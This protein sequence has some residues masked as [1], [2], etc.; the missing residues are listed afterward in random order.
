[1][2]SSCEHSTA[3]QIVRLDFFL[4]SISQAEKGILAHFPLSLQGAFNFILCC[5]P[6]MPTDNAKII[7]LGA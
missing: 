7:L 5:V 6:Y 4:G 3:R 2:G 1:M